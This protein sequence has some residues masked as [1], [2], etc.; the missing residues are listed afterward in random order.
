MKLHPERTQIRFGL[1]VRTAVAQ[2]RSADSEP[3]FSFFFLAFPQTKVAWPVVNSDWIYRTSPGLELRLQSHD[4]VL[5]IVSQHPTFSLPSFPLRLQSCNHVL[6][7]P[8]PS[9]FFFSFL[10]IPGYSHT[11]GHMFRSDI[12]IFPQ[13]WCSDCSRATAFCQFQVQ[14]NVGGSGWSSWLLCNCSLGR[15]RKSFWLGI[16]RMRSRDCS[17]RGEDGRKQFGFGF[18]IDRMWSH[19]RILRWKDGRK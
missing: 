16:G 12:P 3:R 6:R 5:P 18:G 15:E 9:L 17:L 10:S 2:L 13:T 1:G 14:G 19:D 8:S 11:T 7:I 4:G